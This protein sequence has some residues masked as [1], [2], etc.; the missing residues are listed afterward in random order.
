MIQM[1]LDRWFETWRSLEDKLILKLNESP[2]SRYCFLEFTL[3]LYRDY[4]HNRNTPLRAG[5]V[6]VV[7]MA[8]LH[9]EC[10]IIFSFDETVEIH[11]ASSLTRFVLS[12]NFSNVQNDV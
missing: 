5:E 9:F 11:D 1:L 3:V 7:R 8:Q 6:V 4:W 10:T 2:V 12:S